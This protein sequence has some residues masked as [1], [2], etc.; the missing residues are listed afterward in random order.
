MDIRLKNVLQKAAHYRNP[1]VNSNLRLF[2]CLHLKISIKKIPISRV[3]LFETY[4][5][6][7]FTLVFP[8]NKSNLAIVNTNKKNRIK[9]KALV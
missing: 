2:K 6:P 9:A 8:N 7:D 4:V 1:R 3:Y 5:Y